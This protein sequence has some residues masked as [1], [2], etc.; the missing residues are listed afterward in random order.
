MRVFILT[1]SKDT[2]SHIKTSLKDSFSDRI[3]QCLYT[4]YAWNKWGNL[5]QTRGIFRTFSGHLQVSV[6]PLL[7]TNRKVGIDIIAESSDWET[8][9]NP[10]HPYRYEKRLAWAQRHCVKKKQGSKNCEDYWT[11]STNSPPYS[12]RCMPLN[13]APLHWVPS[14]WTHKRRPA[15]RCGMIERWNAA[16]NILGVR[17]TVL[18]GKTWWGER[19]PCTYRNAS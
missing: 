3:T 5:P 1:L 14:R 11:S 7:S 17:H 9:A 15:S 16:L 6:H 10:K 13:W 2:H 12:V 18:C 8:I 4:Y 19:L